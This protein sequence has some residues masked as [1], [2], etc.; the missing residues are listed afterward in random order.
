MQGLFVS[1]GYSSIQNKYPAHDNFPPFAGRVHSQQAECSEAK[2][3][4]DAYIITLD[5]LLNQL[6]IYSFA[7]LLGACF[8]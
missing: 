7:V 1:Y 3:V 8:A 5:R 2:S 6:D 4:M